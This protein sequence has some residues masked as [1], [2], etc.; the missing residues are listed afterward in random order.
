MI[1]YGYRTFPNIG[2]TGDEAVPLS[3]IAA[4]STEPG[5]AYG[6]DE[7]ATSISID[8]RIQRFDLSSDPL[9]YA[10]EQFR[11]DDDVAARL[12]TRYPG[13]TRTFQDLR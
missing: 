1:D 3:R 5:L 8:P 12:S 10:D 11:I 9:A 13:D 2:S 4:R 7:D 6:T